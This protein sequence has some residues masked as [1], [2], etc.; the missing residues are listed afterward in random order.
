MLIVCERWV[1]DGDRLLH[2]APS[3]SD[4]SSTSFSSWLGLLNRGS[5]RAQSP[6]STTGS[7]FGILSPTDSN[8][9]ELPQTPGY[10]IVSRPPASAVLPLIYTG[11]SLDWR[12]GRGLYVTYILNY[13]SWFFYVKLSYNKHPDYDTKLHLVVKLIFWSSGECAIILLLS[14]RPGPL[15]PRVVVPVRVPSVSQIN[16]YTVIYK[17]TLNYVCVKILILQ[18]SMERL[19]V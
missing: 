12:L 3:S 17:I 19:I 8:S 14:L 10:I 16:L 1:G 15:W 6:L 13:F 7:H 18:L 2:I 11:T 5:L 9:L 4:H